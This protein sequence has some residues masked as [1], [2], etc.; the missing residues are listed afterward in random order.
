MHELSL[1]DNVLEIATRHARES[2]ATRIHSITL[3]IGDMS[4]VAIEA[5]TFAFDVLAR[6]TPAAGAELI[7]ERVP[8][9]CRC[10]DCGAEFDTDTPL[11]VC[12]SCGAARATLIQGR[13]IELSSMEV[14]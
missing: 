7:I 6:D 5:L 13:E 3:R 12:T 11:A 9:R 14:S 4:G 2:R 8:A 10:P 1:M